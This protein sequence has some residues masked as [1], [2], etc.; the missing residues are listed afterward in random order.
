M[1]TTTTGTS[2]TASTT[3]RDVARA[4]GS[5]LESSKGRTAIADGV[6]Q[7]VAGIAAREVSGV[8]ALG[9]GAARTFGA[10]RE[11]IP[12]SSQAV[13]QGVSVEVGERQAAIDLEVV[14]EYGVSISDLAAAVRKNV[15]GSVEGMTGLE[16]TEVNVNVN[17]IHL[18][19]DDDEDA[20]PSR[21]V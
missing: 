11:R 1:T 4:G 14:V 12:G 13:G 15:I 5:A 16:V 9:G 20:E 3:T 18:P 21:V 8:H 17:D 10:I 19:D 7:K 6:V 2:T